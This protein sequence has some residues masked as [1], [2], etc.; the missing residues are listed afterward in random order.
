MIA[1]I[2][3]SRLPLVVVA[4]LTIAAASFA[5]VPERWSSFWTA[6]QLKANI[7]DPNLLIIDVRSPKAYAEGHIPGAINLPGNLWRTPATKA[8]AG[9]S[10][11]EIFRNDEGRPDVDRY[12]ALLSAAGIKDDHRVVV[13]G[14]HAGKA[15]GSVPA[16]ILQWL[17]HEKVAFLD[18]IGVDQWTAAGGELSTEPR[19]L[20]PSDYDADAEGDF[21]WNLEEVLEHIGDDDV[22]FFDTRSTAEYNGE[23]KRDNR[24]GGRIPGAIHFNYEDMMSP[25]TKQVIA[26]AEL[27]AKLDERGITKD[28]TVVLYCQTATR[29]SLP[30]LALND[31]GFENVVVYDTSWHEYGNRDDTPIETPDGRVTPPLDRDN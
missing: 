18:G 20:P 6:E 5:E 4:V 28:K 23:D 21:V 9:Q 12:E 13:Y 31:L 26:P 30:Q 24:R 7:D 15:D 11:Q 16:A 2:P 1:A 22:I 25:E 27:Q 14:S 17:G 8:S 3:L 29:T 10:S 19:V